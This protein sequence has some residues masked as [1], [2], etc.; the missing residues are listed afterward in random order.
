MNLLKLGFTAITLSVCFQFSNAIAVNDCNVVSNGLVACYPFDGDAKDY[1][2]N[3]NHGTPQSGISYTTGIMNQAAKLDGNSTGYIRVANPLQKFDQQ[4]TITG[5]VST[6]G[7]GM[8]IFSK[9]SWNGSAGKGFNLS[10]TTL[11]GNGYSVSGSTLFNVT[12]FNEGWIPSKYPT[13]TLPV[14]QFQYV[15]AVYNAGNSMLYIN[16]ELVSQKTVTQL[17]S[18]DNPYDM[19]IGSYF[20][21]NG[22]NAVAS[23]EQRTFDGLIDDL[24]IYNRALAEDEIQ[25]LYNLPTQIP[26]I[27]KKPA[28]YDIETRKV[29]IKEVD[30]P[31]L[32]IFDGQQTGIG[33]FSAE[34]T[35]LSGIQDFK[36]TR[37]DFSHEILARDLSHAYYQYNDGIYGNGGKLHL[38][39]SVPQVVVLPPNQVILANSKLFYVVMRHLAVQPAVLHIESMQFIR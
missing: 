1:S 11:D 9:Y 39:V 2:G 8:P 25:Q 23:L 24:R 21:D 5:W 6:A 26:P 31:I 30:V 22:T 16:G 20:H 7:R 34:L 4:Y 17:A 18:L 15:T 27:C 10:S 35:Q 14:N 29:S 12:L 38:C 36:I 3:N 37:L 28:E 33:V 32:N 19:L 13:Y